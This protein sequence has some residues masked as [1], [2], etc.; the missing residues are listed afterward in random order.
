[1]T[2]KSLHFVTLAPDGSG[3]LHGLDIWH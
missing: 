3:Q 2:A 1:M